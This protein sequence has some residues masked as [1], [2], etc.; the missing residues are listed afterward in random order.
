MQ[1]LWL[2]LESVCGTLAVVY[3]GAFL[4]GRRRTPAPPPAEPM[5]C[6]A[7]APDGK[8]R[9][10]EDAFHFGWHR[11]GGMTWFGSVWARDV[12]APAT[13]YFAERPINIPLHIGP[14]APVHR[15]QPVM[16]RGTRRP[17][18]GPLRDDVA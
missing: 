6:D 10:L 5:F 18:D 4:R 16:W 1:S 2:V 11:N 15:S 12:A 13:D 8:I 17:W 3:G 14:S 9:C 7:I